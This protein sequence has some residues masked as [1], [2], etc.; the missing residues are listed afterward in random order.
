MTVKRATWRISS[1]YA[2]VVRQV[3]NVRGELV[4]TLVEVRGRSLRDVLKDI[5]EKAENIRLNETPAVITPQML[6]HCAPKLR[7]R[8]DTERAKEEKDGDLIFEIEAALQVVK[9][10][11][12]NE[13]ENLQSLLKSGRITFDTI[14]A[15]V[16]PNELV[17]TLDS[18]KQPCV[19][20]A[21]RTVVGRKPDGTIVFRISGRKVDSDGQRTGWTS[22]DALE[23]ESFVGEKPITDLPVYPLRFHSDPV[24]RVQRRSFS[25]T[26]K[27]WGA[28]AI[29]NITEIQWNTSIWD[30]LVLSRRL[31]APGPHPR[32][33]PRRPQQ[34]LRRLRPRLERVFRLAQTWK[35]V[36]LLDEA[37]VFMAKRTAT[38]LARNAVVS[39]FLRQLEYYQGILILTTNR[40]DEIDDAFR[41]R[42]H[43]QLA[44]SDLDAGARRAIWRGF[45]KEVNKTGG[46][47]IEE[48][49]LEMNRLAEMNMNGRQ[50]KNV[51]KM[52]QL[53]AADDNRQVSF[54]DILLVAGMSQNW[55]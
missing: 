1:E 32:Q 36:L 38:D 3:I 42:I 28:F 15:I 18:L 31:Q 54:D 20:R 10:D 5:L 8:L 24:S 40:V 50:I 49:G 41:S 51:M 53:F 29:S 21:A 6:Y 9:E 13:E 26:G 52:S 44:Y 23:I 39:I 22:S 45:L 55:L 11:L 46:A 7:L 34:R 33:K 17:Y 48:D 30:S 37:D 25:L 19:Y 12:A 47:E 4:E 16:P 2:L 27:L 35:A 43:F 14:W